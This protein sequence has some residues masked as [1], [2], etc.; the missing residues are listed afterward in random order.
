MTDPVI[1]ALEQK[2]DE[3]QKTIQDLNDRLVQLDQV[4]VGG[5]ERVI[6]HYQ[7]AAAVFNELKNGVQNSIEQLQR[8]EEERG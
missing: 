2:R 1:A 6:Q 4:M 3:M 8:I 7:S 5:I